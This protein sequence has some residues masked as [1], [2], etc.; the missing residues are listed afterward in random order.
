MNQKTYQ[1]ENGSSSPW[2]GSLD[3]EEVC[4]N[5]NSTKISDASKEFGE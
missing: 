3:T 4:A 5:V 1:T 2:K